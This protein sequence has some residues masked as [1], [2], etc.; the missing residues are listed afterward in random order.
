[1]AGG[2]DMTEST[3]HFTPDRLEAARAFVRG[4]TSRTPRL[5]LVLGSG[6]GGL[7]DL[8]PQADVIP[9][10]E[11]PGFPTAS[12]PGHAGR[13]LL[14]ELE[15]VEVLM[16]AGRFHLYEGHS[17]SVVAAPI[18][19]GRAL[20]AGT[21]VVTNAAGGIR[22]GLA[23]GDLVLLRD[24]VNFQF[25][26]TLAGPVWPG[27]QRF[28]DMTVAYD[29]ELRRLALAVADAEGIPLSEGVYAAVLGPAF[30]TPAEIQLLARL[31][32]D[33][34]GMSTVPEVLAARSGGMRCLGFSLVTNLAAGLSGAPLSHQEVM[35]T[36][37][38]SAATLQRLVRGILRALGDGG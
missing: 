16:Q 34:V 33:L 21:L 36:G 28:T 15:G 2:S 8:L 12:V 5:H 32:V 18:R 20:G 7:A 27:E 23:P 25:R 22:A 3:Q 13:F 26:S 1:T 11:I 17:P 35:E 31:G 14:G 19:L 30:E 29:A 37:N 10:Q 24:H 38:R 6:L 9:F 4:R